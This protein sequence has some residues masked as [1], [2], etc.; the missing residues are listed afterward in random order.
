MLGQSFPKHKKPPV[1]YQ[2]IRVSVISLHGTKSDGDAANEP[3][4]RTQFSGD[5]GSQA[6]NMFSNLSVE[7]I[8]SVL[9]KRQRKVAQRLNAGYSRNDIA[10]M[11]NISVQAIHQIVLRI[12]RRIQKCISQKPA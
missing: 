12:R 2:T 5:N 10:R 8:L 9:T 6:E 1:I 7:V 4:D 11:D 3:D